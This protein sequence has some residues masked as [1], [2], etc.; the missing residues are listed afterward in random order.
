MDADGERGITD[1]FGPTA[2]ATDRKRQ[3]LGFGEGGVP[4]L[5]LLFYLS[6]LAFATWYVLEYQLPDFLVQGPQA[7]PQPASGQ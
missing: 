7:A 2:G 3:G 4:W 5:L 1:P 6:F